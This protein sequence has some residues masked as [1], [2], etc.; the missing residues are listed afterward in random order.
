LNSRAAAAT[1]RT[2]APWPS[3]GTTGQAQCTDSF[4]A[5]GTL[6]ITATY[7][8]YSSISASYLTSFG[9]VG[10]EVDNHT[11]Q[12]GNQFCNTG[13]IG[14]PN[15]SGAATPYPSRILVTGYTGN[16]GK[17]TVQLNGI[18]SSDTQPTDLL[19][20]GPTDA[21]IIPFAGVGNATTNQRRGISRWTMQPPTCWEVR[22]SPPARSSRLR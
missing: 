12:N 10:Q 17:L 19:L 8:G 20:M 16:I 13:T 9:T 6:T 22:R 11:V 3:D 1:C 4:A 7:S 14:V 18:N 2:A 21:H 5:E 15:A